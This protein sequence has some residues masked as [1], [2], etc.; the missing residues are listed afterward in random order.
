MSSN[1]EELVALL[2]Y[3]RRYAR[4]LTGSQERGDRY[5]RLFLEVILQEP[6][7]LSREGDLKHNMFKAFHQTWDAV[8]VEDEDGAAALSGKA[9]LEQRIASLPARHR[10]VLLLVS[11][12]GFP[13]TKAAEILGIS[14]QEARQDLLAARLE[15][16]RDAGAKVLI[17]EDET[18]IAMD[19]AVTVRSAGHTV[20]G[21]GATFKEAVSLAEQHLPDLVLA[22]IHLKGGD[23]GIDAVEKILRGMTVPVIFITGFP[24]ALLTGKKVE[25]AFVITKPFD[26]ETLTAAI[27]QALSFKPPGRK[28]HEKSGAQKH[29]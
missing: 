17:I 8:A 25:P 6:T 18:V 21:V 10:Q 29:A 3:L 15:L 11:L 9:K 4:A 27:G 20:V 14:E 16:Q 22:D 13:V 19:V 7:R 5:V 28:G 1:A 12:E 26:P 24:E 23:S 2:P